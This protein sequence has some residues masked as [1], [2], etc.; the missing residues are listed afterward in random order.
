L[1]LAERAV[2]AART[3]G[4]RHRE[5]TALIDLG[6][7]QL[8]QCE[9]AAAAE[10]LKQALAGAQS[11]GDRNH[12]A[13]AALHLAQASLALGRPARAR[14]LLEPVLVHLRQIGDRY[15]EK[16][17]TES[18]GIALFAQRDLTG[19]LAHFDRAIKIAA[20][21]GDLRHEAGVLW[22][23]A[24]IHAE[25]GHRDRALASA[26][27]SVDRLQRLGNP[28]AAWYA[29][30]L[31][32]YESGTPGTAL[33]PRGETSVDF[34]GTIDVGVGA[35]PETPSAVTAQEVTGPG[36]LRMAFAATRSITRFLGSGFKTATPEAYRERLAVCATCEHHTGVRCRI[37]G[38]VTT[39]KAR[40]LHE[41]CPKSRWPS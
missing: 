19:A 5:V 37:C 29:H 38:C 28:T 10:L 30:H 12:E 33:A 31:A 32:N 9:A 36:L 21:L 1:A 15:A 16:L 2:A 26:S 24:I 7:V 41:Q 3:A 35:R 39:V 18:L 17:A 34:G 27:A 40:L 20:E 4:N 11:L 22:R 14:N 8:K 23:A 6:V 13:D 25:L